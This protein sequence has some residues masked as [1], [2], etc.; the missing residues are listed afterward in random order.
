MPACRCSSIPDRSETVISKTGQRQ[1]T[2]T[3]EAT[4]FFLRI[5]AGR[6]ASAPLLPSPQGRHWDTQRSHYFKGVLLRAGAPEGATPYSFRHS[7][8]S[9]WVETGES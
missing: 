1:I 3:D 2:L 9:R 8:I 7:H 5:T 4:V 6:P